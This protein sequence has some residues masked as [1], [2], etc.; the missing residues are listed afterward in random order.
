MKSGFLVALFIDLID[1]SVCLL[2][3]GAFLA[4]S[5]SIYLIQLLRFDLLFEIKTWSIRVAVWLVAI[6]GREI[7]CSREKE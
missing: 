6:I 5:W 4:R 1:M 3:G 2:S 7:S